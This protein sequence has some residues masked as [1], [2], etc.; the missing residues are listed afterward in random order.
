MLELMLTPEDAALLH[1]LLDEARGELSYELAAS[2]SAPYK[3]KLA[4]K[5]QLIES[6][7][8]RLEIAGGVT[9]ART[10]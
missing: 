9:P 2:D 1:E 4:A 5:R 6:L 3:A 10:R 8:R 7:A